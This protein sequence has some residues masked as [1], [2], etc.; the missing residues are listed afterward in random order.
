MAITLGPWISVA[1]A[2]VMAPHRPALS[3]IDV[4]DW[5]C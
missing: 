2:L 5:F 4:T 1:V 3:Q